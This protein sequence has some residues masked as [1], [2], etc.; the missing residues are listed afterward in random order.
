[1]KSLLMIL[2]FRSI[3]IS[4]LAVLSTWICIRYGLS[5]EF[6][7]P[8]ILVAVVFPIVFSI[9]AAYKRREA[10]LD[11]YGDIKAHV[12]AMYFAVRDWMEDEN[13]EVLKEAKELMKEFLHSTRALFTEPVTKMRE[14]EKTVY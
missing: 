12:Q 11:Q 9:D 3:W 13:P 14:N 6:P 1:M 8:L 7:L 5:A 10:A 2:N 4:A